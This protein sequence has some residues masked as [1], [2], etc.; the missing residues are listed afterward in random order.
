ME[1]KRV[2][3][4]RWSGRPFKL[5]SSTGQVGEFVLVSERAILAVFE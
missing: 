4:D 1:G 3:F 5:T 2:F